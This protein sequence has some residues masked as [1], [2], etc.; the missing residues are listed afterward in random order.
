MSD[1]EKKKDEETPDFTK[2][3]VG[4]VIAVVILGGIVYASYSM[5]QKKSKGQTFPAGFQQPTSNTPGANQGTTIASVNCSITEPNPENIWA[6][7]LK[8][9]KYKTKADTK[10]KSYQNQEMGFEI[11]IPADLDTMEYPNG[12]GINYKQ[13][14]ASGDL[15]FSADLASSRS[16]EF[17]DQKGDV[18]VKNYWRQYSGLTSLKSYEAFTNQFNIKGHKATY[19]NIANESPNNEVFFEYPLKSGD[20]IHFASG[21]LDQTVFDKII[22][23]FKW[24]NT[25]AKK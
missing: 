3:I 4:L 2:I 25:A 11:S 6:Y 12:L 14:E 16:G 17:K 20:Y 10:W 24:E 19:L 22:D 18:Y 15:L 8:C 23:S 7:Y 13:I 5:T 9:D 1:E 21:V